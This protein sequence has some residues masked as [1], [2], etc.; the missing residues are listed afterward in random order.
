VGGEERAQELGGLVGEDAADHLGAGV[1]PA[2][3]DD[4]PE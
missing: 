1:E 2:V 4:V 3:A